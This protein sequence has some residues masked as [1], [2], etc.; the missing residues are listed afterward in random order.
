[1]KNQ[2]QKLSQIAKPR[3]SRRFFAPD[4]RK[5][6]VKEIED[7]LSKS[8]AARKYAVSSATIYKWLIKYSTLYEKQLVTIVEHASATNQVLLKEAELQKAYVLLGKAQA[9]IAYLSSLI[10][11]A[12]DELGLDLKKTL[13]TKQS[14]SSRKIR[15]G[16]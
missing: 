6:I 11:T 15:E 2:E 9:E 7:G 5:A 1:M 14:S 3:E 8:E 16:Q 12:K 13:E 4:V 10:A